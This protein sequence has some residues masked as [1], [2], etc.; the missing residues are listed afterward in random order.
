MCV[1]SIYIRPHSQ[2]RIT[3]IYGMKGSDMYGMTLEQGRY[4]MDLAR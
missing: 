2:Q 3:S 1:R 4:R